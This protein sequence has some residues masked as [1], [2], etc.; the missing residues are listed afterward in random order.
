MRH[1]AG[2]RVRTPTSQVWVGLT[3]HLLLPLLEL[4]VPPSSWKRENALFLV[5]ITI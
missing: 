1:D 3:I 2:T 5:A 4:T